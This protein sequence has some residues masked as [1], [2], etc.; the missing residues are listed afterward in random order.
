MI[1]AFGTLICLIPQTVVDRLSRPRMTRLGRAADLSVV[2]AL[3]C[4]AVL[5]IASQAQAAPPPAEHVQAGMGMGT[6]G[7]G[8]AS[9]NRPTS[10]TEERAMKELLC[11]CGCAREDIFNCKCGSAAQLRRQ[12]MDFLGKVDGQGKPMFNLTTE[13]GRDTAY[14]AVLDDFVRT[15]GGEQVLAT[16]RTKFSWLLPSLAV[17]GSLAL[18]VTVGRRW[19]GRGSAVAA[20]PPGVAA[21]VAE[22]ESYADKL[23]DELADTD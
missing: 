16:P 18:L 2:I 8:Y 15:Y 14:E 9:M 5:G 20:T 17:L 23:D 11:I 12:V 3:A 19:I 7:I 10:P 21:A 1:L 4:A 13:A 6:D 22:D